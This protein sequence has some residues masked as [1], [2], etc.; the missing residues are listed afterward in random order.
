[1]RGSDMCCHFQPNNGFKV[2][3][4]E[5]VN[6][7]NFHFICREDMYLVDIKPWLYVVI[8]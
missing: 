3:T 6:I 4:Y 1:M 5:W 2:L 7:F 8:E